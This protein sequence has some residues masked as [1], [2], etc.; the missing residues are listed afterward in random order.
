MS[1]P[2]VQAVSQLLLVWLVGSIV[3]YGAVVLVIAAAFAQAPGVAIALVM[4]AALVVVAVLFRVI[5]GATK[6]AMP[7]GET[8]TGRWGWTLLVL[9]GGAVLLR[10][11]W[12]VVDSLDSRPSLTLLAGLPFALVAGLLLRG[13]R[14]R[15]VTAGVLLALVVAGSALLRASG[16]DEVE[17]R[18]QAANLRRTTYYLVDIPGYGRSVDSA[19]GQDSY[20]PAEASA[21]KPYVFINVEGHGPGDDEATPCRPTKTV[22]LAN[23]TCS[24]EPGG[25]TFFQGYSELGYEVDL[26]HDH[27]VIM[28][29]AGAE[30]DVLRGGAKTLHRTGQVDSVGQPVFSA[31]LAGFHGKPIEGGR[32]MQYLPIGPNGGPD[33]YRIQLMAGLYGT[34]QDFCGAARCETETDGSIYRPADGDQP[35]TY[36]RPVAQG[37]VMVT[38]GEAVDRQLLHRT[39]LAARPA[40]DREILANLR[41]PRNRTAT[42][43]YRAWL[44]V[45]F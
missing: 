24:A 25:L 31:D 29:T 15:A 12:S 18:L 11:G 21:I 3:P 19:P 30:R 16:P 41:P 36:L 35:Q 4:V 2:R 33:A 20:L 6:S 32:G 14:P 26:G 7:L 10:V 38:G 5:A 1:S 45:H 13:W 34:V 23:F 8:G 43:R 27:V 9:G 22:T 37:Q 44:K 17:E 39:V 40:T 28:G 42:E